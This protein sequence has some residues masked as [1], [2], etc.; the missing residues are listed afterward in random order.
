MH[1]VLGKWGSANSVW[2]DHVVLSNIV[3]FCVSTRNSSLF[4]YCSVINH[5][6]FHYYDVSPV[7]KPNKRVDL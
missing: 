7:S 6:R 5:S 1:D 3:M 4:P 2:H